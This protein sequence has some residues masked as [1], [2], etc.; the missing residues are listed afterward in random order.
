MEEREFDSRERYRVVIGRGQRRGEE[1]R[2]AYL[3]GFEAKE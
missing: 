1:R 3:L 2:W